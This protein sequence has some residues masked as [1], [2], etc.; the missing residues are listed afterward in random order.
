MA[1]SLR[2][3][4]AS[5]LWL[6]ALFPC[7]QIAAAKVVTYH[8]NIG[9]ISAAPDGYVRPVIAINGLFPPPTIHVTVG[10][11]LVIHT[12]NNLGNSSATLHFHGLWQQGSTAQ[13]GPFQVSQ[14]GVPSDHSF[15][16]KFFV[17]QP[18]TYFYHS[19][20]QGQ[21][22]DGLRAPLIVHDP[23]SPYADSYDE[24]KVITLSDWYHDQMPNLSSFYL[25]TTLNPESPE[26][27]PY[28]GL[29]SD[30]QNV[31]LQVQPGKTYFLRI[32]NFAAFSQMYLHFDEHE[33]TII[34]VDGVYTHPQKVDT[35]YVAVAQRY[36]VLLT[37]KKTTIQNYAALAKLDEMMF[38]GYPD[39]SPDVNPDVT[40]W[41][42]YDQSLP[43]P[44]PLNI[45]LDTFNSTKFDDFTLVPYDN[46]PLLQNPT[47]TFVLELDFFPQD[48]QNRA[49]FNQITWLP[50]KVPS[51]FTALTTGSAATDNLTY[52][53]NAHAMVLN[54]NEV[55]EVVINNFDNGSHPIHI[56]GHAPQ[57]VAR[58]TNGT[59]DPSTERHRYM[60]TP[61]AGAQ[62]IMPPADALGYNRD[63]VPMPKI[64]LKRDTWM[65]AALGY[66]V[67]R[68][69]ANNPGVWFFHCHM[70]WHNI[71]GL[72]ATFIEAPL[73]LQKSQYIPYYSKEN[74]LKQDMLVAGNA[75]GNTKNFSDLTG[76]VTSCPPLPL[77]TGA[78]PILNM[79][80]G[81]N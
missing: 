61:Q 75:A 55:I 2:L 28:S 5:S 43:L 3:S 4:Y 8:F 81:K 37:T 60:P 62:Y 13:D 11:E 33:M 21:Y 41:L 56:H 63:T 1:P 77:F 59:Y 80:Y 39:I 34:E 38:D 65:L 79:A 36:G 29:L 27:I 45:T 20:F 58:S 50:Q 46:E 19:H 15:T 42:V 44:P 35:L 23:Y 22:P 57:I 40:A 47:Q 70:D 68:F 72:A 18:G 76:A 6:L 54:Y 10:D 26:P 53:L 71:A 31:I 69:R 24:E 49:G 16:Y 48:G 32:I 78:P 73:E 12:I 30:G 74:C 51:L 66:T 14:C 64:P 17:N 67:I 25:N 7:L 9:W 52:G